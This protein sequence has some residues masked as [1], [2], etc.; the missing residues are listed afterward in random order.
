MRKNSIKISLITLGLT[1]GAVTGLVLAFDAEASTNGRFYVG[2]QMGVLHGEPSGNM[3]VNNTAAPANTMGDAQSFSENDLAA[4]IFGGYQHAVPFGF[5]S[6][7]GFYNN[8]LSTYKKSSALRGA[9]FDIDLTTQLRK[10]NTFG[11]TAKVGWNLEKTSLMPYLS[12][13]LVN[14]DFSFSYNSVDTIGAGDDAQGQQKRS[15]W[16]FA[17]GAGFAYPLNDRV[18]LRV[19]YQYRFYQEW[20]LR[21]MNAL[22]TTAG[23]TGNLR[24]RDQQLMG[25]VIYKF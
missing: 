17:P 21:N 12:M 8:E 16:A 20:N 4:G 11:V 18:L 5:L 10:H 7:E 23:L 13:S 14:S 15:L 3:V 24:I 25:G 9:I 1:T 6:L 2:G 22:G 19:D